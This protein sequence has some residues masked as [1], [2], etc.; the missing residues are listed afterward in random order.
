[1][2]MHGVGYEL[3]RRIKDEEI[4][5]KK[6]AT[7]KKRHPHFNYVYKHSR[8][9]IKIPYVKEGSKKEIINNDEK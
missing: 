3:Y 5:M 4:E 6:L 8:N 9:K 7:P 1:M 2:A